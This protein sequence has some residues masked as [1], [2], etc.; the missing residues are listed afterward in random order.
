MIRSHFWQMQHIFP[1]YLVKLFTITHNPI[2]LFVKISTRP[3][4][5]GTFEF[6]VIELSSLKPIFEQGANI[7]FIVDTVFL[8]KSIEDCVEVTPY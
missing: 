8:L 4:E 6:K 5:V 7:I 3:G 2:Q 1:V